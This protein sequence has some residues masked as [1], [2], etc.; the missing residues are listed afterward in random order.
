MAGRHLRQVAEYNFQLSGLRDIIF[1]LKRDDALEAGAT[2][3]W[4]SAYPIN[5]TIM[6]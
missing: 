3:T 1:I 2:V 5:V 4:E 6:R